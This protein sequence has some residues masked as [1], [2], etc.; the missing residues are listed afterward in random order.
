MVIAFLLLMV[1]ITSVSALQLTY[2][3]VRDDVLPG[4]S[5]VYTVHMRNEDPMS[6]SVTIK[7]LDLAWTMDKDAEKYTIDAGQTRDAVVTYTP[8]SQNVKPGSYGLN[9]Q[10]SSSTEKQTQI[11]PVQ[12][13]DFMEVL[14]INVPLRPLDPRRPA[15]LS[16]ALK[17]KYNVQLDNMRVQVQS[18]LFNGEQTVSLG[19]LGKKDIEFQLKLA[20][21][22]Q[23]GKY[24]LT[25]RASLPNN[26]IVWDKKETLV[27]SKYGAVQQVVEEEQGFFTGGETVTHTNSANTVTEDVY[28]K[29]LGTL[30]YYVSTFDPVPS[31]ITKEESGYRV[32]WVTSLN[33]GQRVVL[34]YRTNYGKPLLMGLI[35]LGIIVAVYKAKKRFLYIKKRVLLLHTEKGGVGIMK[36]VVEVRN[37]SGHDLPNVSIMDKVPKMINAP[38]DFGMHKPVQ[39]KQMPDGVLLIW[40]FPLLRKGQEITVS[41]KVATKTQV[42]GRMVLPRAVVKSLVGM[43]KYMGHSSVVHLRERR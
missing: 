36:V 22:Q 9:F 25:V 40:R 1:M 4:G 21:N 20:E 2:E 33:P 29:Q 15:I 35:L 26:K 13:L 24:D 43:K 28:E 19:P 37:N 11:L 38:T 7:S 18:D 16:L 32:Q 17:N 6:I 39:V 12:V 34:R 3:P 8:V 10:A 41:Y 42:M 30:A 27:V 23:E 31:K 14:N 5:A